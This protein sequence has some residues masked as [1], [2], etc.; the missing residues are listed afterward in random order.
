MKMATRDKSHDIEYMETIDVQKIE[1]YKLH[2]ARLKDVGDDQ[3]NM[4]ERREFYNKIN[5]IK[6]KYETPE[7]RVPNS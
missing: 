2:I 6:D 3:S 1:S 5:A 7:S 4:Q